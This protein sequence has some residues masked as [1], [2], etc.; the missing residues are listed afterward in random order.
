MSNNNKKNKRFDHAAPQVKPILSQF[1]QLQSLK[2]SIHNL[3]NHVQFPIVSKKQDIARPIIHFLGS[4]IS[5]KSCSPFGYLGFN[6]TDELLLKLYMTSAVEVVKQV[7]K[8]YKE[9]YKHQPY[10]TEEVAES[11]GIPS[12]WEYTVPA[13]RLIT[14][15]RS[16]P[17][18]STP[19]SYAT[20]GIIK[21]KPPVPIPA[22]TINIR[23][24]FGP[25][26]LKNMTNI[27]NALNN[28]PP[29]KPYWYA[30]TIALAPADFDTP[31]DYTTASDWAQY[32]STGYGTPLAIELPRFM[33]TALPT[34]LL[35]KALTTSHVRE[36]YN[37]PAQITPANALASISIAVYPGEAILS[38]QG[39][40]EPLATA[41]AI[42]G[43]QEELLG[44]LATLKIAQDLSQGIHPQ[45][46]TIAFHNPPTPKYKTGDTHPTKITTAPPSFY[47]TPYWSGP[48]L[49]TAPAPPST[50][51]TPSTGAISI[52]TGPFTADYYQDEWTEWFQVPTDITTYI[53]TAGPPEPLTLSGP[54][55]PMLMGSLAKDIANVI[56][57]TTYQKSTPHIPGIGPIA[58][59]TPTR[60]RA[61]ELYKTYVDTL[62]KVSEKV[63]HDFN[64]YVD[65][66]ESKVNKILKLY[67]KDLSIKYVYIQLTNL[68]SN[69]TWNIAKMYAKFIITTAF[70]VIDIASKGLKEAIQYAMSYFNQRVNAMITTFMEYLTSKVSKFLATKPI[71]YAQQAVSFWTLA[72]ECCIWPDCK[73]MLNFKQNQKEK[74]KEK[75]QREKEKNQNQ[76]RQEQRR[77]NEKERRKEQ[78]RKKPIVD[79]TPTKP[80]KP[81]YPPF[82]DCLIE[83]ATSMLKNYYKSLAE[84]LRQYKDLFWIT[85]EDFISK[86]LEIEAQQ[87]TPGSIT[88]TSSILSWVKLVAGH[89][90]F[91]IQ[92]YGIAAAFNVLSTLSL[93]RE[94]IVK[95]KLENEII[96]MISKDKKDVSKLIIKPFFDSTSSV[97]KIWDNRFKICR[98]IHDNVG[99]HVSKIHVK[100]DLKSEDVELIL[101]SS[102]Y[103]NIIR[104]LVGGYT[105]KLYKELIK[106][107]YSKKLPSGKSKRTFYPYSDTAAYLSKDEWSVIIE[108]TLLAAYFICKAVIKSKEEIPKMPTVPPIL[109][110]LQYLGWAYGYH[111]FKSLGKLKKPNFDPDNSIV[112]QELIK[113]LNK[114]DKLVDK[115]LESIKNNGKPIEWP[116]SSNEHVNQVLR[117]AGWMV[118]SWASHRVSLPYKLMR[119]KRTF[120][121]K[122][123]KSWKQVFLS[124][125]EIAKKKT[126]E[127]IDR[128]TTGVFDILAFI[129]H[130]LLIALAAKKKKLRIGKI[131]DEIKVE[132]KEEKL[133]E[134]LSITK[135]HVK[136]YGYSL[137]LWKKDPLSIYISD[138]FYVSCPEPSTIANAIAKMIHGDTVK[139][140]RKRPVIET[141][142]PR[143]LPYP[144]GGK[145]TSTQPLTTQPITRDFSG[146]ETKYLEFKPSKTL[147]HE[148]FSDRPPYALAAVWGKVREYMQETRT[149]CNPPYESNEKTTETPLGPPNNDSKVNW[150][151][152]EVS[153]DQI[154]KEL[155]DKEIEREPP[156]PPEPPNINELIPKPPTFEPPKCPHE[157][158]TLPEPPA[159]HLPPPPPFPKIDVEWNPPK[160]P[161]I[162]NPPSPEPPQL[163]PTI[164]P[165]DVSRYI[166]DYICSILKYTGDVI[167]WYAKSIQIILKAGPFYLAELAAYAGETAAHLVKETVELIPKIISYVYNTSKTYIKIPYMILEWLPDYLNYIKSIIDTYIPAYIKYWINCT[168]Y[169]L[170][171]YP[172]S[173]IEYIRK[174]IKWLNDL[175]KIDYE[176]ILKE[177]EDYVKNM[178]KYSEKLAKWIVEEHLIFALGALLFFAET[179][180]EAHV[181]IRQAMEV[182]KD[183][184]E[185]FSITGFW[186]NFLEQYCGKEVANSW[187]AAFHYLYNLP[188]TIAQI[189]RNYSRILNTYHAVA[190]KES[191]HLFQAVS[192]AIEEVRHNAPEYKEQV[193]KDAKDLIKEFKKLYWDNPSK[194]ESRINKL[195]KTLKSITTDNNV[196]RQTRI[197]LK[198]I[199]KS[200]EEVKSTYIRTG[201]WI[202]DY[203]PKLVKYD[204]QDPHNIITP[205]KST[206]SII[207]R[208]L[209]YITITYTVEDYII[210]PVEIGKGP[211]KKG[212]IK[213][214]YDAYVRGNNIIK[215]FETIEEIT[216]SSI[217]SFIKTRYIITTDKFSI[218]YNTLYKIGQW[219]PVTPQD[220]YSIFNTYM[221]Q[222][223]PSIIAKN[224]LEDDKFIEKLSNQFLDHNT[225][226]KATIYACE[227]LSIIY[228]QLNSIIKSLKEAYKDMVEV[229]RKLL[230]AYIISTIA[231][232]SL[233]TIRAILEK[234]GAASSGNW[235][236]TMYVALCQLYNEEIEKYNQ[237]VKRYNRQIE[238]LRKLT[239]TAI[240]NITT[241]I[242]IVRDIVLGGQQ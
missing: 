205:L 16:P 113:A 234:S 52:T 225:K 139:R 159:F 37:P 29:A 86:V 94:V 203:G 237:A 38:T 242:N 55:I 238:L 195:E 240:T 181:K 164:T 147:V 197:I 176:K 129:P 62:I 30:P 232:E 74:S 6:L 76:S 64:Q 84:K 17:T 104:K 57:I 15:S 173:I 97:V 241:A 48:L 174:L 13:P 34:S 31:D 42:I 108:A 67:Y 187:R 230:I 165:R 70:Y 83:S 27:A 184:P 33:N 200:L 47:T 61:Y 69:Y 219:F 25:E 137:P 239:N 131:K 222:F 101:K 79:C 54:G 217:S 188:M 151:V 18:L 185:K 111:A 122:K 53:S 41:N 214:L 120:K 157:P 204:G 235:L 2:F 208:Q 171:H 153:I 172:E 162:P 4:G 20:A 23:S 21:E 114:I 142:L 125:T 221:I 215:F 201:K 178:V 75:Q 71:V 103:S 220:Y 32:T 3:I 110:A 109:I 227:S 133:L 35:G 135:I 175:L 105:K 24:N 148:T 163:G 194:V 115:W 190:R 141:E 22:T 88:P 8:N 119:F 223:H 229:Y 212:L 126:K 28:V 9:K 68:L 19:L 210:E 130:R 216:L 182:Y 132:R 1:P 145:P 63:A 183:D 226:V 156:K 179:S 236:W 138:E 123:G 44:A 102:S 85:I 39:L 128:V 169:M 186:T 49:A 196:P 180:H 89:F 91:Y 134:N 95:G 198:D 218:F 228:D 10:I 60:T 80:I 45:G 92:L 177:I 150:K 56:Y 168:T 161:N 90:L 136:C 65:H 26:D 140:P 106:N 51:T 211:D 36:G 43:V 146:D 233:I 160:P 116:S 206:P 12:P 143:F 209:S 170:V 93:A 82:F 144:E 73:L 117:I 118:H 81:N 213:L 202:F 7:I 189:A 199:I 207:S 149:Y 99:K 121:S 46:A 192:R 166:H 50:E 11:V 40:Q 5:P 154:I 127:S 193:E 100:E 58:A 107:W 224:I 191:L 231:Y 72:A 112:A 155:E 66:L 59:A 14:I 96:K 98:T 152:S 77:R 124:L 158:P 167:T 87:V 78:Q